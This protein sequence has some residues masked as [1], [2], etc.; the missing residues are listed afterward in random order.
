MTVHVLIPVFNRLAMTRN[1][2]ANLRHQQVDEALRIIVVDD[3]STDGT[4]EFLASLDDVVVLTG[5]GNL[6]WG[7]AID[8]G[9]R[10]TFETAVDQDWV[11]FVN[12]DTELPPDFI[13][14][15][16][17]AARKYAPAAVGSVVRDIQPPHQLISVG[18]RIDVNRFRVTDVG[19]GGLGDRISEVLE[20]DALSGRG[21]IFPV[22]AL[23]AAGG[24]RPRWLPQYLADYELSL[25]IR[26]HGWR[27]LV[28]VDAT[29]YSHSEFGSAFRP[30]GLRNRY[31][32]VRSPTYLPAQL[33]FWWQ[34][35][36]PTGRLTLLPQ[37]AW[38][39]LKQRFGQKQQLGA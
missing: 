11:V 28:A 7:G 12:N 23:R 32:S 15:L 34:A 9:L 13:Q 37:L 1:V 24:M 35:R 4:A 19:S 38:H 31:F 21:V 39:F 36:R 2:V 29:V 6:W 33:A 8:L 5:N 26:A 20:V 18:P 3:G 25:R 17:D 27:L 10:R 30:R 14:R 22:S 16:L